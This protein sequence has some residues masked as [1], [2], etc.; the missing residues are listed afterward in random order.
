MMFVYINLL[1]NISGNFSKVKMNTLCY[2]L[3]FEPFVFYS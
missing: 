2:Y 3:G 1:I